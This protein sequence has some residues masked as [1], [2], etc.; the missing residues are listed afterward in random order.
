MNIK[1]DDALTTLDVA[2]RLEISA[3]RVRQLEQAGILRAVKLP[4]GQ[5]IFSAADVEVLRL[6][7]A[8]RKR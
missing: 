4:K 3:E 6:Q 5:R 8:A 1:S 2:T 7:R